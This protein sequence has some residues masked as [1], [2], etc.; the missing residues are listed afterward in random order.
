MT[1]EYLSDEDF[2]SS[3]RSQRL[4][5]LEGEVDTQILPNLRPWHWGIAA[6]V[7]L[8]VVGVLWL[9][10]SKSVGGGIPTITADAKPFKVKPENPGGAEVPFQEMQVYNALPGNA[11]PEAM[12]KQDAVDKIQPPPEEPLERPGGAKS[13]RIVRAEADKAS[14]PTETESLFDTSEAGEMPPP[15]GA[16]IADVPFTNVPPSAPTAAEENLPGFVAETA[17]APE[18]DPES[19]LASDGTIAGLATHPAAKS[20]TLLPSDMVDAAPPAAESL[21]TEQPAP[22]PLKGV[23]PKTTAKKETPRKSPKDET[24]PPPQSTVKNLAAKNLAPAKTDAPVAPEPA[25]ADPVPDTSKRIPF[26]EGHPIRATGPTGKTTDG[27][28]VIDI[29][30]PDREKPVEIKSEQPPKKLV[31]TSDNTKPEPPKTT[32]KPVQIAAV[33]VAKSTTSAAQTG[34]KWRVQIAAVPQQTLA[35]TEWKRYKSRH[36][37]L[38][39]ALDVRVQQVD[40]GAKG[41]FYR[42]QAGVLDKSAADSTCAGLRARGVS[43]LVVRD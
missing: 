21:L 42:V 30:S 22:L 39:G 4:A 12:R 2:V 36:A 25:K 41:T 33:S 1:P 26:V 19:A 24:A 11:T 10:N 9:V 23:S 31:I 40:L 20:E 38:L 15:V 14:V 32:S 5:A 8:A 16:Q 28:D 17:P 35:M 13:T 3:R 43:C 6:G 29:R 34:G 7:V 37:D 18:T 27:R